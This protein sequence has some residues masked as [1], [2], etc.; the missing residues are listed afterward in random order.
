FG[1][2]QY[3]KA[4]FNIEALSFVFY[5][6][7]VR[8]TTPKQLCLKAVASKKPSPR[9][10]KL[11]MEGSFMSC[12]GLASGIGIPQDHRDFILVSFSCSFGTQTSIVVEALVLL[13]GLDLC[14][15][16]KFKEVLMGID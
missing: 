10:I 14:L 12:S 9:I 3:S 15:S 4:V 5:C 13:K 6:L 1:L 7:S 2:A 11:N 16:H 8:T